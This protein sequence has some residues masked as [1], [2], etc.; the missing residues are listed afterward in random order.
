VRLAALGGAMGI[1]LIGSWILLGRARTTGAP[2][3]EAAPVAAPSPSS[4]LSLG[5]IQPPHRPAPSPVAEVSLTE[6]AGLCTDLARVLDLRDIPAL[7]ERAA[8]VLEAKGLVLWVVDASGALLEPSL[9]Q[10][11]PEKVRLRMSG[12]QIDGD[13][14]TALAYRSMQPQVVGGA[15][16]SG[17]G[18]L[19]VPLITATGCVGVLSAE[20]KAGRPAPGTVSVAQMIA[21]QFS[22]LI[23]PGETIAKAQAN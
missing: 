7:F 10:G 9:T 1:G 16:P 4:S 3:L 20:V 15:S 19:A 18:A 11:Y 21:A 14:A 6:A 8:H 5:S 13:N 12:L 23:A 22:A 2:E 17:A